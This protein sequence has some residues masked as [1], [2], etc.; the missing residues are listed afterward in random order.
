MKPAEQL[1]A[2]HEGVK[3]M[4]RILDKVLSQVKQSELE[5]AFERLEV[6]RIGLGKHEEFHK[7]LHQLKEIYLD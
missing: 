1:K 3:L 2:E 5:E 6:E 4:L 7:L